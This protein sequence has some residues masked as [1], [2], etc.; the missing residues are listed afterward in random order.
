MFSL[1]NTG[2]VSTCVFITVLVLLL[3]LFLPLLDIL[4]CR[5]LDLNL[6]GGLSG[7]PEAPVLLRIRKVLLLFV[8]AVY[9]VGFLYVVFFSRNAADEYQV[10]VAV[11]Q[12]LADSVHIDF[13]IVG[14]FYDLLNGDWRAIL[15]HIRITSFS[16]LAQ[17]YLNVMLFIPMGYLLPYI[18]NWFRDK[19]RYRP[20]IA[21]FVISLAVENVQL[22]TRHGYYDVDDL[23]TNTIGGLIGEI[24][25]ILFA[26][27]V[28]RPDWKKEEISYRRWKKN[29]KKRTLYPFARKADS[30]RT[31][32]FAT[33]ESRIW[34]FYVMTLGFRVIR[35]LIPEDGPG[36]SFLL[37]LGNLQV[38]VRCSNLEEEL[39]EQYLV[40]CTKKI[41]KVR[42][43]LE[44][45]GIV[46]HS[47][48]QDPYTGRR[49]FEFDAPD[50]VRIILLSE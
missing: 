35:Q 47:D 45:N 46:V 8:L 6:F 30:S 23:I 4:I 11:F 3:V 27:H 5:S 33:D 37:E 17:V 32:L 38:E 48:E 14:A 16:G 36:T 12:N 50:G 21:C 22:V 9:M 42:K 34:D 28:T 13:G 40:I 1:F 25:F 49:R 10:H 24:L 31:V 29:A 19:V 20:L 2:S 41:G 43:R 44:K 26:F 18:F 39:R 15:S 7:N